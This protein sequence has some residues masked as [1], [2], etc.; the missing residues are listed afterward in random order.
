M[1]QFDRI[2]DRRGTSAEK[3]LACKSIFGSEDVIPMWV[4][5]MDVATA[6]EIVEALK[7]RAEHGIF[8]YTGEVDE[9]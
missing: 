6:P 7:A 8:G 4:A 1:R 3:L 5:D 9:D 2:I